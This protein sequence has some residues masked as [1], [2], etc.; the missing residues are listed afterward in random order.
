[1]DGDSLV[2]PP[3]YLC[4]VESPPGDKTGSRFIYFLYFL[5]DS[6]SRQ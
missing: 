1:M 5:A 6:L 4:I 2:S 3:G